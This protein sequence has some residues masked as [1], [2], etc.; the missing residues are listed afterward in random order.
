MYKRQVFDSV[1]TIFNVKTKIAPRAVAGTNEMIN[2]HVS[3]LFP[4]AAVREYLQP[5]SFLNSLQTKLCNIAFPL[6]LVLLI[7]RILFIF[8]VFP[9]FLGKT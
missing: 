5:I 4:I 6:A 9:V 7:F 2:T 1:F 8:P 3:P